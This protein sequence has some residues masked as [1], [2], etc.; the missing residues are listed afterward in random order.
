MGSERRANDTAAPTEDPHAPTPGADAR[1]PGAEPSSA[2]VSGL[3]LCGGQ[4]RRM[5]RDKAELALDGVRLIERAVDVLRPLVECGGDVWLACGTQARY[6]ELG[7]PLCL[8][9]EADGGPLAGIEAGLSAVAPGWV[10]VLAVDMPRARV[11]PLRS[12]LDRARSGGVDAVLARSESGDEPLFGVYHTRLLPCV[13]RALERGRRR[14]TSF[15]DEPL[16]DLHSR[17][18]RVAWCGAAELGDSGCDF[19]A[20]LNTPDDLQRE[21]ERRAL[22]AARRA[23]A[24]TSSR[25]IPET[26]T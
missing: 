4:S 6:A 16:L 25:A 8:D 5:G 11:E 23:S 12:L 20:N 3:V 1:A 15:L 13:R 14:V 18:P 26:S 9:R 10:C 24:C 21:L 19:A 17:R 22:P 7:R 2:P